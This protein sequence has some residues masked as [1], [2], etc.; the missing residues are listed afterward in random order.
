MDKLELIIGR[1][2]D[3]TYPPYNPREWNPVKE[4]IKPMN[5]FQAMQHARVS[6]AQDLNHF[7]AIL[8]NDEADEQVGAAPGS[9]ERAAQIFKEAGLGDV[10]W[11]DFGTAGPL[12]AFFPDVRVTDRNELA[13]GRT[14]PLRAENGALLLTHTWIILGQIA[15]RIVA[16]GGKPLDLS[17]VP[18]VNK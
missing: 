4:D 17:K 12:T 8:S 10:V 13:S 3:G 14:T 6:V 18:F 16:E 5:I 7:R 1:K 2:A 15:N 11:A 9:A